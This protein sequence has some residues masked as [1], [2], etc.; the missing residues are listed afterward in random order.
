[1]INSQGVVKVM[2]FGIARQLGVAKVEP[3]GSSSE[4]EPTAAAETRNVVGTPSYMS[5]EAASGIVCPQSD[6]YSLGVMT[7]QMLT[8]RLPFAQTDGL[9]ERLAGE[10]PKPSV[11]VPGLDPLIDGLTEA[12]LEADYN[13][14]IRN[15][16]QFWARLSAA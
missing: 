12:S 9:A 14:R 11:L 8:G 2:D 1:M 6:I 5:P 15:A 7:Y 4:S 16:G 3:A 10:Y 13:R